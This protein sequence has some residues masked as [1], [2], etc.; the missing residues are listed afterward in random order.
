MVDPR[1]DRWR[2]RWNNDNEPHYEFSW[3]VSAAQEARI[4]P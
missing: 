4:D 2:R 1:N 3:T